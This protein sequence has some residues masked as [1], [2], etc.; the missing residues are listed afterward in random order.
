MTLVAPL[1]QP[2][3]NYAVQRDM[4]FCSSAL[5][6]TAKL[7]ASIADDYFDLATTLDTETQIINVTVTIAAFIRQAFMMY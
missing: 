7:S 3:S 6:R 5:W 2:E 4:K 1:R